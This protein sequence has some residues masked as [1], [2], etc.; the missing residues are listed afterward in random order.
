MFFIVFFH[1]V[2]N[3]AQLTVPPFK[4]RVLLGGHDVPADV[5]R[6]RFGRSLNNFF[7]LYL[8]LADEWTLFDNSALPHAR[9]VAAKLD[10]KLTVTELATWHKLKKLSQVG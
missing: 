1:L 10:G 2:L 8:P 4:L 9:S 6:R 3:A 5:I 7:G